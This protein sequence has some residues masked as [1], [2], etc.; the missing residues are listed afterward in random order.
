MVFFE[1]IVGLARILVY[2]MMPFSSIK[3]KHI[4]SI[5]KI[6]FTLKSPTSIPI[7]SKVTRLRFELTASC[8][9]TYSLTFQVL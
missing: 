3:L 9:F 5:Q 1:M 7:D 4:H 6:W 2:A 8:R